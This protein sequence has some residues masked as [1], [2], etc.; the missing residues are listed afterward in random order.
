MWS[1]ELREVTL[2]IVAVLYNYP[3]LTIIFKKGNKHLSLGWPIKS[4]SI[5]KK[6]Y[7]FATIQ[8][9]HKKNT[10]LEAKAVFL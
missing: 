10:A 2:Y 4:F 1:C 9:L 5:K 6:D 8:I 7:T 3:I